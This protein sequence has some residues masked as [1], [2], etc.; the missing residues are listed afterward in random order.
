MVQL[1][2]KKNY[3]KGTLNGK[4][5]YYYNNGKVKED[6]LYI[7]QIP[8]KRKYFESTLKNVTSVT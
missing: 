8:F 3:N 5:N 4:Y 6:K 1:R 7:D 2:E